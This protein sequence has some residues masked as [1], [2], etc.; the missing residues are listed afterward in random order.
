MSSY[1]H[2]HIPPRIPT[3]YGGIR[4]AAPSNLV[5]LRITEDEIAMLDV[6]L[7]LT[8]LETA[9][10]LFEWRSNTLKGQPLLPGMDSIRT[11]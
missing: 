4:M 6:E 5:S 2:I 3:L 8:V 10:M 7:G 9:L 1:A 11:Q